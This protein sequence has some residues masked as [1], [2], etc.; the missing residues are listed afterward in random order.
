M[1]ELYIVFSQTSTGMAVPGYTR[2][3]CKSD[4]IM[5]ASAQGTEMRCNC[6]AG[7]DR[8]AA[9]LCG[10]QIAMPAYYHQIIH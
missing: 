4:R 9:A 2:L 7:Q 8:L 5:M 10:G 1:Q 6:I 3:L